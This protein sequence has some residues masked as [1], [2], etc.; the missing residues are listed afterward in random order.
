MGID[1]HS[2]VFQ[3]I[4]PAGRKE[5]GQDRMGLEAKEGVRYFGTAGSRERKGGEEGLQVSGRMKRE[6]RIGGK[7]LHTRA[8]LI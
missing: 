5:D 8:D 1:L 4:E 6:E 2:K 7:G 3:L